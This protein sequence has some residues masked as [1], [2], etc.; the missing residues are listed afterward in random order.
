MIRWRLMTFVLMVSLTKLAYG[1]DYVYS[2]N[3]FA[4]LIYHP[5]AAA[6]D[7]EASLAFLNRKTQIGPGTNYQNN[8]L[9]GK[10][11]L[12]DK[13]S[14]KRFGGIGVHFL[15]KDAGNSDLLSSVTMG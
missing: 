3:Q 14:G 13:K 4:P 1:Q 11:P 12:V 6:I 15:Q 8:V 5:S 7:N 9:N 2:L 10:Y